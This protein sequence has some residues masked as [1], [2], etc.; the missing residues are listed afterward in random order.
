M[1]YAVKFGKEHSLPF[2]SLI[3]LF[4]GDTASPT[5]WNI[6]FADFRLPPHKDDVHLNDRPVSRAEQVDDNLIMSTSFAAFQDKV[7]AFYR[8]CT[9]KRVFISAKK[10]KWMIFG[11]LPAVLPVLR[12]GDLVVELVHE[13]KYVGIWFTSVHA[14]VF[15]KHYQVK[16]SKARNTSNAIFGLNHRIGSLPVREG[17]QLYMARVDCYLTSGCE[18]SL[19]TDNSLIQEHLEAQHMFLCRLLG[20]NPHSMLAILFTETGQMPVRI[21]R[22]LLAL[23]R[24]RYMV[25]I[26]DKRRVVRDALLDSIALLREGQPGWASDL[27]IMLRRL[28]TPIEVMADKLL[29]TDSIEAIEKRVIAIADADLQ[30][31]I[32]RLVKTHLIRNRLE[33]DTDK[34]LR[35]V[36]RR[37]RHYLHMVAVHRKAITG[38][39]LGD[40][41]LSV[42]RLRY[43]ARYRAKVPREFILCRF[44]RGAVEDKTHALLDCNTEERLV[45]LRSDFLDG[46]SSRDPTLLAL[47]G[48]M[49][50]Y[51]FLLRLIASRK[52]VQWV[53]KYI[54]N[55]LTLYQESPRFFPVAFRIPAN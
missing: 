2:H 36:T 7:N 15:A 30:H 27:T 3:G 37:L 42:E 54:F 51:D 41:N 33:L 39:L 23:G 8:W 12:I 52:L 22:L 5:L 40:H 46:I 50:N 49:S 44:C 16:V 17:L 11:P 31:D 53:A 19:D 10:S 4:T 18:I 35:L 47:H 45:M 14:D 32:D 24:L 9:N 26:D 28:P 34:S 1:R 6:F 25:K 21:R 13:F 48:T 38:L 29:C 43:P 20:L 55:V